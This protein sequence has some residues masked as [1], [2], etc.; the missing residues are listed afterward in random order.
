[1]TNVVLDRR[2]RTEKARAMMA[3]SRAGRFAIGAF[4]ADDLLTVRAIC[5]AAQATAAPVIVEVSH[6]EVEA[7]G[8]ENIRDVLDNEVERLGIEA[9]LNLD[10]APTAAA[11]IAGIDAGCELVHL[12][13][14]QSD[15]L[16]SIDDVIAATRHVVGYAHLTGALVEGEPAP[17]AGSSTVH[18]GAPDPGDES[19]ST[20]GSAVGFVEETGVDTLAVGLGNVH[21]RYRTPTRLN[22]DLLGRI[23]AAVPR[24]LNLSLHG[25]SQTPPYVYQALALAGINKVNVNTDLRLAHRST[26]ERELAAHP[27]EYAATRLNRPVGDA[28]QQAV[29]S[30]IMAFGSAGRADP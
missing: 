23:R 6:S 2:Q 19:L 8:L 13:L 21:G 16:A 20:P 29:E 26:L 9:Y 10:H 28:V 11:A 5:R 3:R 15:P 17:F 12:D 27:D 18:S 14:F 1:M 24:D 30:K 7:L 4:N 25:G 22:V